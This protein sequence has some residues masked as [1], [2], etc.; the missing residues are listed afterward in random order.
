M[1]PISSFARTLPKHAGPHFPSFF[2]CTPWRHV[3]TLLRGV[4]PWSGDIDQQTLWSGCSKPW[5][6]KHPGA[7][8]KNNWMGHDIQERFLM[9]IGWVSLNWRELPFLVISIVHHLGTLCDSVTFQVGIS[10]L[11]LLTPAIPAYQA[12]D[13]AMVAATI[14]MT[15]TSLCADYLYIGTVTWLVV[16]LG[17][18]GLEVSGSWGWGLSKK[19]RFHRFLEHSSAKSEVRLLHSE[20]T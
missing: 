19:G 5:T 13:M 4:A 1:S 10:C 11:A 6:S 16:G 20:Q 18:V 14:L 17:M 8:V 9:T 3:V 12:D 2:H 15:F 7:T